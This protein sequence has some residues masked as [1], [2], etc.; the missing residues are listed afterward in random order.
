MARASSTVL[1][2]ARSVTMISSRW[3]EGLEQAFDDMIP[4]LGLFEEKPGAAL[5]DLLAVVPGSAPDAIPAKV[6]GLLG[7][8]AA[9]HYGSGPVRGRFDQIRPAC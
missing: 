3:S 8:V 6:S 1:A 5:D 7:N 2:A 9:H 4:V